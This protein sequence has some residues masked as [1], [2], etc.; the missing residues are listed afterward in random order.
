VS[1]AALTQR[2]GSGQTA[3]YG[4][5]FASPLLVAL[6][7]GSGQPLAGQTITFLPAGVKLSSNSVTTDAN[8][9][10][11]VFASAADAG[12]LSVLALYNGAVGTQFTL[13]GTKAPLT[14]AAGNLTVL[15]GQPIPRRLTRFQDW[16]MATARGAGGAPVLTVSA[17]QGMSAGVYPITIRAGAMADP[18]YQFVFV[19]SLVT[20][21]AASSAASI[22]VSSGNA[23]S[24]APGAPLPA[25]LTV[26]VKTASGQ[27]VA[28]ALVN[29]S[30][31]GLT[32]PLSAVLTN[33]SGI[34]SVV[35]YPSKTGALTATATVAGTTL[36]AT[37]QETGN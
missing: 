1:N 7:N 33:A 3:V 14:V 10:A 11:L 12:S 20:I 5:P 37:F 18:N 4:D 6:K 17:V 32:L 15:K 21:V 30:G 2:G 24:A 9:N 8:G 34:A 35:A 25:P 27:A 16:P 36:S 13:T 19:P 26:L 23:Q 31:N 28:N 29:F 22:S